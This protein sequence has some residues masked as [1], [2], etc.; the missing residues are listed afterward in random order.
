MARFQ[1]ADVTANSLAK[2]SRSPRA[3][4]QVANHAQLE[5]LSEKVKTANFTDGRGTANDLALLGPPVLEFAPCQRVPIKKK[6]V[7]A[8]QGT[9]DQDPEFVQFLEGLTNQ[10]TKPK[11]PETV[12]DPNGGKDGAAKVTPLIQHL[13]DKKAAREKAPQGKVGK[14]NKKSSK[15]D[16]VPE[17]KQDKKTAPQSKEEKESTL[18]K[19]GGRKGDKT[20]PKEPP[21]PVRKDGFS[22]PP[23]SQGSNP[24]NKE[25]R[26]APREPVAR[27]QDVGSPATAAAR[28]IRRDLGIRSGRGAARRGGRQLSPED[29][30]ATSA[31]V[32]G[33]ENTKP[34][35]FNGTAKP[36]IFATSSSATNQM[37]PPRPPVDTNNTSPAPAR[38]PTGPSVKSAMRSPKPTM[39]GPAVTPTATRAF[40]KH[41]NPSQGITEQLL[42][43][44]L[45]PFGQI[46]FVEIDKRKGF[47]YA[48]FADPAGLQAA[49]AASPV[50]VAQGSVQVH[51]RKDRGA[52]PPATNGS[53]PTGP[54]TKPAAMVVT[55]A[56]M[57]PRG[58]IGRGASFRGGRAVRGRA[59][60]GR[61][62]GFGPATPNGPTAINN[63]ST[64]KPPSDATLAS[65]AATSAPKSAPA[66]ASET[67]NMNSSNMTDST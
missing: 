7:D 24:T 35:H 14:H 44:A 67:A 10:I 65:N 6:K 13:R 58:G 31:A 37:K 19:K 66:A 59:G 3:Y 32:D 48:E 64:S 20:L 52:P 56:A 55:P 11:P 57:A 34:S 50:K 54:P 49:I 62:G 38:L 53:V 42:S 36:T 17:V 47:A 40:L 26:E 4:F 18:E 30:K 29:R 9:I 39:N 25:H 45:A 61:G 22:E 41:A 60:V 46:K 33:P 5:L 27:K 43:A 15:E 8:R 63:A 2:P 28:M 51:E 16:I 21:K 23:K 1:K 12:P